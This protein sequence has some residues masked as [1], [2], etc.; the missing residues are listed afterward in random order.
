MDRIKVIKGNKIVRVTENELEKYLSKGYVIKNG[1]ELGDINTQP[2][3]EKREFKSNPL[4][5]K[6][7][8]VKEDTAQVK[9]A[10]RKSRKK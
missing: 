5:K 8:E 6:L 7:P 1:A 9:K 3:P 10:Q 4:Y 2:V